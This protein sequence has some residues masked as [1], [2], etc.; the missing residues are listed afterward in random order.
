[1][2]KKLV[3]AGLAEDGEV[4]HLICFRVRHLTRRQTAPF[5]IQRS[6]FV[7]FFHPAELSALQQRWHAQAH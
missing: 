4:P 5:N 2:E 1:M 6:L 3:L 7:S